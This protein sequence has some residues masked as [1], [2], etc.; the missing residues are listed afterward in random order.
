VLAA[1]S[2]APSVE[3]QVRTEQIRLL[4]EQG[5]LAFVINGVVAVL[6]VVLIGPH[7]A[8]SS[9][10]AW[11]ACFALA[12]ALR[13]G[14]HF[15]RRRAPDSL[16][17]QTWLRL[18]AVGTFLAGA[19]W[20]LTA[21]WLFPTSTTDRFLDAVAIMGLASGAAASLSCVRGIYPLYL[22]PAFLPVAARFAFDSGTIPWVI[23][24]LSVLYCVGMSIAAS[25]NYKQLTASLHLRY[26]NDALVQRL[27][28]LATHDVLTGLANRRMLMDRLDEALRRS[29]RS[30]NMVAVA[31]VDCDDF[32]EINDTYGHEAGDAFL[33]HVADALVHSVR[34]TDTVARFGGDEFVIVLEEVSAPTALEMVIVRMRAHA[35]QSISIGGVAVAPRVSIGIARYPDDGADAQTLIRHADEAMYRAKQSGGNVAEFYHP[36]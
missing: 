4:Y 19:T 23:L 12:W 30:K 9:L 31:F 28:E 16:D 15:W 20:G 18:F 36:A 17:P 22:V 11:S 1:A 33:K 21:L 24:A 29:N 26:E 3:T 13:G 34:T 32:K 8:T 5:S 7:V 25:M 6:L 10:I 14:L 35:S 27:E 2:T